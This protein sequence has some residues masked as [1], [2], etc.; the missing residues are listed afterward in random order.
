V[1][2]LILWDFS[3]Y[4][5]KTDGHINFS[6]ILLALGQILLSIFVMSTFHPGFSCSRFAAEMVNYSY[7]LLVHHVLVF[8]NLLIDSQ[9]ISSR[10]DLQSSVNSELF[11]KR[12]V[13]L[14]LCH[15]FW[16][17]GSNKVELATVE[18]RTDYHFLP[19]FSLALKMGKDKASSGGLEVWE[20][21][22]TD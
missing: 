10:K 8:H 11:G 22:W 9:S 19:S 7:L 21:V 1:C 5:S 4:S 15:S 12:D 14:Y 13:R 18:R 17:L 2:F 20:G 16:L 3:S 6:K